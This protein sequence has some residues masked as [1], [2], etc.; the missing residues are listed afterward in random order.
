MEP[1]Q[2][3]AA[4][5]D[6][7]HMDVHV[8]QEPAIT[9][10]YRSHLTVYEESLINGQ[11][12]SRAWNGAGFIN[13]WEDA[14]LD[15]ARHHT[16]FTFWVEVD[17]QLLHSHWQWGGLQQ[18]QIG[19]KLHVVVD[20]RHGVRPIAVRVHTVLDG[21]PIFTR[22]LEI[23]NTAAV[24]S[25]LA[26]AYPWT[27]VLQFSPRRDVC[28]AAQEGRLYS[29]GYMHSTRWGQEGDFR[30]HPLPVATYG[31]PGKLSRGP[32]RHPMFVLRNELSGEHFICQLAWSGGFC[33]EFD[34]D[35]AHD[36]QYDGRTASTT[37]L[38]FKA[39]PAAPAPQRV[40]APG[41]TVAT[42]EV[43]L[44]MVLGDLDATVQAMH[45]HLRRS[46]FL[47][48]VRE[49]PAPVEAGIGP[50]LE[51]TEERVFEFIDV[52]ARLG[53]EVFFIDASWYAPARSHWWDTVGDWEV[54]SRFPRGLAP[55]RGRAHALG[56]K[57]GLWME[58]E[59]FAR[60]ARNL[61]DHPDFVAQLYTGEQSRGHLDLTRPQV[62]AWMEREIARVISEH[63]LDF[64]RLDYNVGSLGFGFQ[65][66]HDGF[67]ENHYWRYYQ[68]LY[69]I[70]ARLRKQFPA[71]IFENCASGGARTDIGMVR[72]FDHTW[73]TDW[74][75]APRSF[76]ITNGMT[77]A[78][79]PEHV[80][81]L[82]DGQNSHIRA[83]IDF[84]AR[85]ILFGRPTV[86][87]IFPSPLQ[88]ERLT[89]AIHLYKHFVRPFHRESRI[90]HHTPTEI[91]GDHPGW[92]V[93]ELDAHDRSRGIA[94]FFRLAGAGASEYLFR[95]R[96]LDVAKTY[97]VTFDNAGQTASVAGY[98]LVT[99]GIVIRLEAALTSELVLFEA[100]D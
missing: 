85:S 53:A 89:H 83:H 93:L 12:V 98:M 94:A 75:I 97:A 88:M 25:T 90:F 91:D 10:A 31:I 36:D 66:E 39:G 23:T 30:W 56:M 20:L 16:P 57:F 14:R 4:Q 79:P 64:F 77:I 35:A 74:Q 42:P 81:R 38:F 7:P 18:E 33:F 58:A 48:E 6:G 59:R 37:S 86:G 47:P 55:F 34:L 22:W 60:S 32:H 62:A 80:D 71:V 68:A 76:W 96:G 61:A 69:A 3:A 63:Q 70:Y 24:P 84:Q 95:P 43:H 87:L 41:E 92:G 44:G 5:A 13:P 28:D 40:L 29:V 99:Q 11:L 15:P 17:G 1:G 45:D 54:G 51:I 19:G 46:V 26:A 65:N 82:F 73:V 72:N 49:R 27:G 67:L 21:T 8:E 2:G 78:L 9:V 50:E 52:G 100:I